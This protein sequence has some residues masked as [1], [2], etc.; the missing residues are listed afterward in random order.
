M[1]SC[2]T[3]PARRGHVA[4]PAVW[5]PR[6][7]R[8][9]S[10]VRYRTVLSSA[11]EFRGVARCARVEAARLAGTVDAESCRNTRSS[12]PE[13]D[14]RGLKPQLNHFGRVLEPDRR[15]SVGSAHPIDLSLRAPVRRR[16]LPR[17][18]TTRHDPS[19]SYPVRRRPDRPVVGVHSPPNRDPRRPPR[20]YG[21][22][23]SVCT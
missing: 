5:V 9:D 2:R 12:T 11:V 10:A 23:W 14:G 4:S 21:A 16:S 15:G 18:E 17:R 1:P 22:F 6:P 3:S 13:T 7:G 19:R 20:P 8:R